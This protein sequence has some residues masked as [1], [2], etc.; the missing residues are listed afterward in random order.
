MLV[1][2]PV[3]EQ[4]FWAVRAVLDGARV[5]EVAAEFGVSRQSMHAWVGCYRR[6]G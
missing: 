4:R 3:V 6:G 2:L 1:D 5:T